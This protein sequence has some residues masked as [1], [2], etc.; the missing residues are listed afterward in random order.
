[1]MTSKM[2]SNPARWHGEPAND[3]GSAKEEGH[4]RLLALAASGIGALALMLA[5]LAVFLWHGMFSS[6][7][8]NAFSN[9][10]TQYL[11]SLN[12]WGITVYDTG[13]AV[14]EGHAVCEELKG[15]HDPWA[16]V[17]VV[18]AVHRGNF[19]SFNAR[20][21]VQEAAHWLCKD[22]DKAVNNAGV[23]PSSE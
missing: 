10:E 21:E 2:T 1:M 4:S 3:A 11:A 16:T 6:P 14:A 12:H 8:A 7:S 20:G 22:Q 15:R 9:D 5:V 17:Y 18:L 13:S 19:T 23:P